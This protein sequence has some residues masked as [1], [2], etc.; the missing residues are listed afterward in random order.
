MRRQ[1]PQG[2][3]SLAPTV[4]LLRHVRELAHTLAK[5]VP[6]KLGMPIV[7]AVLDLTSRDV[8][9][10]IHNGAPTRAMIHV[11]RMDEDVKSVTESL[12]ALGTRSTTALTNTEVWIRADI[13]ELAKFLRERATKSTKTTPKTKPV[14]APG[15]TTGGKKCREPKPPNFIS[16]VLR[17]Q[18]PYMLPPAYAKPTLTLG[19]CRFGSL[20]HSRGPACKDWTQEKK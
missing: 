6:Q 9:Y 10:L 18:S 17:H 3:P 8:S 20:P 1:P 12:T 15:K 11:V 5:W 13:H 4:D 14:P 16:F 2:K 19:T 7:E